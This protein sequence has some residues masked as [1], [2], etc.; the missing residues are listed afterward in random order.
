MKTLITI[1]TPKEGSYTNEYDV[2]EKY[3]DEKDA[4]KWVDDYN[5]ENSHN[6]HYAMIGRR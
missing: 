4:K 3:I 2:Q 1:E 5:K 6:S